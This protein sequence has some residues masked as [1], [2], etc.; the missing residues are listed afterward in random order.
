MNDDLRHVS[1]EEL[2]EDAPCGFVL[3]RPEGAIVRVN[4]T[5]LAWTGYEQG[6]LLSGRRFQDL[7]TVPGKMFYENQYAPLLRMQGFVKEVAFDLLCRGREP[8]PVLVNAV[9]RTYAD[10]NPFLIAS[11]LFDATDRRAYERELLRARRDAE[12]LARIV[13]AS[14][15]AI[16]RASAAGIVETWNTGAERLFGYAAQ[17]VVGRSLHEILALGQ[18]DA[19]WPQRVVELQA[20]RAVHLETVG[21]HADGRRVD[22]SVGLTPHMDLLGH[23]GAISAIVR[24]IRER[25]AIERL[26]QE[27]LA[28]ATHELRNPVTGIRANAQL[29]RRRARYS[30]RAVDAIVAQA[31]R[32][33]RLI[34]DLLL[35]SQIAADRLDLRQEER[36]LVAEARDAVT[37]VGESGAAIRVEAPAEP[38]VA[39]VDRQRLGQVLANLLTNAIKYSPEGGEIVVRLDRRADEVRMAVIDRGVGIPHHALPHLFD[40]FYRVAGAADRAPGLG[41]GLYISRRIVEAHGGR[42]EVESEP[43]SG[44]TFTV[45]LPMQSGPAGRTAPGSVPVP[46]GARTTGLPS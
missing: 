25:R 21:H 20:G 5:I 6:E 26:Q 19:V 33:G 31:D 40:R 14:S 3:T 42:I 18:G 10:G 34:D 39:S 13:T 29:M 45:V 44:S 28:M 46:G 35:A 12:Q 2:Y 8:L 41:L 38:L 30:E 37:Y 36:D 16:V 9:Q 11:T 1:L 7:L 15:D 27:F 4:R 17:E 23:L 43:D 24:D 32:L 22:V